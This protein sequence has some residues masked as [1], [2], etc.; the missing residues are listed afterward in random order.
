M[1]VLSALTV[2][3]LLAVSTQS[4]QALPKKISCNKASYTRVAVDLLKKQGIPYDK[5]AKSK[6]M[7]CFLKMNAILCP[8]CRGS[9]SCME[10]RGRTVGNKLLQRLPECGSMRDE[11][12]DEEAGGFSVEAGYEKDG[13]YAKVK[14]E[15]DEMDDEEDA[16]DE[17]N[18]DVTR[19]LFGPRRLRYG[20]RIYICKGV[21]RERPCSPSGKFRNKYWRL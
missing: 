17:W 12:E 20:G 8:P 10:K 18:E 5:R 7:P 1:K 3:L 11:M 21:V 13:K 4:S 19:R 9:T 16:L 6:M 15:K 14:W 2:A